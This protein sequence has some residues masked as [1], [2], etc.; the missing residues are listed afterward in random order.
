MRRH[1][2]VV[3]LMASL[4]AGTAWGQEVSLYGTTM[5]QLWKSEVAG[6]DKATFAPATQYLGIDA[7]KLGSENLSL[8][9]FGWGRTDLKEPSAFDG[10]KSAGYLNY[11]YLQ[12]RFG[13][14]NAE[15]KAGRFTVGQSTGFEQVDGVSVRTDLRGG[16]TFSAFGGKPVLYKVVDP[17]NQTDYDFQRDVIYGTRLGWRL[18][19]VGEIGVS[20]LVDGTKAAKD[21]T[22]PSATDY[23]R[24]QL[25]VDVRIAPAPVFDLRGRTVFDLADHVAAAPGVDRKK[26]AEHDYTATVKLGSQVTLSGNVAE[27]NFFAY[28]A[29]TNLPSLFRQNDNDLFKGWGTNLTWNASSSFQVLADY[30]HMHRETF[31]DTNRAGGEMRW[32]LN[33]NALLIGVGAHWVNAVDTKFVDPASPSRSLSHKEAR[34]WT[35]VTKGKFTLSADGIVQSYESGNPY[36]AG[37]KT[38]YEAVGSVGYR[39]TEN[40]KVSGDLSYGSTPLAKG[41]TRGLLRAEYRFGFGKKGGQ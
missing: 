18:P 19:K 17:R 21:L 8:H 25:G 24:K 7:T 2:Y 9:L 5:A 35:M 1:G 34:V 29:G 41:E 37:M 26:V 36:L 28:F 30:R 31:G 22:V 40:L 10:T 13:Q 14:A 4:M 16:F 38:L 39:W 6:F 15:I 23:T 20:Y 11:G 12:Y 33:E 32:M 27:R 3:A